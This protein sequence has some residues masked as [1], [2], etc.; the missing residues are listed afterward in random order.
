MKKL[1]A[2]VLLA[3]ALS[4]ASGGGGGIVYKSPK[5]KALPEFDA[6]WCTPDK[7]WYFIGK[8]STEVKTDNR[9]FTVNPEK[10]YFYMGYRNL[11]VSGKVID[12][13]KT[14]PWKYTKDK[15]WAIKAS[16]TALFIY[17]PQ[18][19]DYGSSSFEYYDNIVDREYGPVMVLTR[20]TC[21]E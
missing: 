18:K 17:N 4:F 21:Y 2:F 8:D 11:E 20:G 14:V 15:L 3:F 19:N 5:K 9:S 10:N 12:V 16:N 1:L 7:T 13:I 6:V